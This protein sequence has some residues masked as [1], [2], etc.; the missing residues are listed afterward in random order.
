MTSTV[1]NQTRLFSYVTIEIRC[2]IFILMEGILLCK[3]LYGIVKMV[4][5]DMWV[6][7]LVVLV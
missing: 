3:S 6:F 7:A 4:I 2:F 5:C 1:Y